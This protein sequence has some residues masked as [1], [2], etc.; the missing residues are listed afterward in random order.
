MYYLIWNVLSRSSHISLKSS[1]LPARAFF[2]LLAPNYWPLV[3]GLKSVTGLSTSYWHSN[4]LSNFA[5]QMRR[6]LT[7]IVEAIH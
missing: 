7:D 1:L 6:R 4:C 3:T 2:R 5:V